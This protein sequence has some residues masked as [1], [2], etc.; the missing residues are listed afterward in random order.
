LQLPSRIQ[1]VI[2]TEIDP[3]SPSAAQGLRKGDI[4][5]E[6]NRK[7]ITNADEAVRLSEEIE[8][9]KV[10]VLIWREG[11]TRYLVVDESKE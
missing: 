4:V 7:P 6:L 11:R 3:D 5:L 8:G 2:I 1:G 10:L 9:P